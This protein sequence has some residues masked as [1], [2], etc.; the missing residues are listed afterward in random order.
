MKQV[1]LFYFSAL[2]NR[3]IWEQP[4]FLHLNVDCPSNG[5]YVKHGVDI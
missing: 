2:S 5:A 4:V 1:A 3:Q